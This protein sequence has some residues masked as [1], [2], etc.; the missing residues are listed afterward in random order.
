MP[1]DEVRHV[2]SF[3]IRDFGSVEREFQGGRRVI[4]M[5]RF[6]RADDGCVDAGLL[7]D[8]GQC[9]L[10]LGHPAADVLFGGA[11]GLGVRG[12]EEV[13]SQLHRLTDDAATGFLGKGPGVIF[14]IRH[15]KTHATETALRHLGTG[16]L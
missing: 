15:S 2:G 12:V 6:G 14:T 8:P 10:R 13:D 5:Q 3:Q 9:D 7:R 11:A 16:V 1:G 4:E